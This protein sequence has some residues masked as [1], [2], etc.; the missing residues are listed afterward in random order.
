MIEKPTILI[1]LPANPVS[2]NCACPDS[3]VDL[4][5]F[6]RSHGTDWCVPAGMYRAPL[7]NDHELIFNSLFSSSIAV[8]NSTAASLLDVFQSPQLLTA[9]VNIEGLVPADVH[10]AI[11]QFIQLG[12]LQPV[13][14]QPRSP[15]KTPHTLTAWLHVTNQCNL[16]CRYCYIEKDEEAMTEEIGLT[17]VDAIFRTA[18]QSGLKSV[19][20]KYA[21]GESSLNFGLIRQLHAHAVGLSQPSHVGLHEV[22]LSNGIAITSAMLDFMRESDIHLMISLDGIGA[23]HDDQ[24][25]FVNGRGSFQ[26]VV[27]GIERA[28]RLGLHPDISIT[29]TPHNADQLW[30]VVAFVLDHDLRFNLNF[31]RD[32]G[33]ETSESVFL[34]Q[35]QRIVAGVRAALDVVAER[36]PSYRLIDGL[37]DRSSFHAPHDIACGAGHNYLVVD[38]HG[39]ISRCQMEIE[40]P[41]TNVWASDILQPIRL[42]SHGFQNVAATDKDGCRDCTWRYWCAGGCPKLTHAATGRSDVR[43]PYCDIYTAI[44]PA[45]LQLEGLR[46][47]KWST[48]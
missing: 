24:R 47:L 39:G 44:Y 2:T 25:P 23:A 36:L 40:Q 13:G 15:S 16:R 45:I 10:S 43:S 30:Q 19:K 20:L 32:T 26:H 41:L 48:G 12:L 33:C 9:P 46:L 4:F 17:A 18:L 5:S 29:V 8:I 37:M 42:H 31:Q 34:Q 11:D 35:E 22:V 1:G 27:R 28:I 38:Q 6:E 21:G 3:G 7:P 14:M